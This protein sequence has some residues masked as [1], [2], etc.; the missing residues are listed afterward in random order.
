MMSSGLTLAL[1]VKELVE[2]ISGCP[3]VITRDDGR[4]NWLMKHPPLKKES[5]VGDPCYAFPDL[6]ANGDSIEIENDSPDM[7]HILEYSYNIRMSYE[8]YDK[9]LVP[10]VRKIL[11]KI[12]PAFVKDYEIVCNGMEEVAKKYG[13]SPSGLTVKNSNCYT[14]FGARFDVRGMSDDEI[15]SATELRFRAVGEVGHKF[16]SWL[17]FGY[18]YSP[19]RQALVDKGARVPGLPGRLRGGGF[20]VIDWSPNTGDPERDQKIS[21]EAKRY[22]E[23]KWA[24]VFTPEGRLKLVNGEIVLVKPKAK[25]KSA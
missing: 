11:E 7:E 20:L 18:E 22:L 15:L 16:Y 12:I 8:E 21:A 9:L 24:I 4:L 10:N 19:E 23:S 6:N 14:K 5:A 3:Y 13:L 25:N 1:K 17:G 2:R